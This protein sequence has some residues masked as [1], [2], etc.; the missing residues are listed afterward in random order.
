MSGER[1]RILVLHW[2]GC[3]IPA[4]TRH[5][6]RALA[7]PG[8]QYEVLFFDI[9]SG[10]PAAVRRSH[11]DAV[12]LHT[13]VFCLRWW[14]RF[15]WVRDHLGWLADLDCPRVALPQDEYDLCHILD[16]WLAE[17]NVS[18]I[19]T[20]FDERYRKLLY[21]R[22][23]RLATFH[24]CLT[25]YIDQAT[26]RHYERR[27]R[28]P[29]QRRL[30]LVYRA[31][32]LPFWYGCQGQL[33]HRIGTVFARRAAERGLRHDLSTRPE[34]RFYNN[35]WFDFLA[36]AR[37]TIGCESGTCTMDPQGRL[38]LRIQKLL[39]QEPNLT[40]EE[41]NRRLPPG[42]DDYRF[43]AISPR[44]FEA[45]ITRTGQILV[46]GE[47]NKILI[48]HR[49]YFPLR[50]D[51]TNLNEALDW[52]LD[53]RQVNRV[54]EAAYE[55][56]YRSGRYNYATLSD[57]VEEAIAAYRNVR[58]RPD[59]PPARP[60]FAVVR[61][62]CRLAHWRDSTAETVRNLTERLGLTAP[63]KAANLAAAF[64]G[65]PPLRRLMSYYLTHPSFRRQVGCKA[66]IRD[67]LLL[68]IL[69]NPSH[70]LRHIR[71]PFAVELSYQPDAQRVVIR[72]KP[73]LRQQTSQALSLKQQEAWEE[74]EQA[75]RLKRIHEVVWDHSR[76]GIYV[77]SFSL[78]G[79]YRMWL[80]WK[81]VHSFAGFL[82]FSRPNPAWAMQVLK[83][84]HCPLEIAAPFV[85]EERIESSVE[86]EPCWTVDLADP[87]TYTT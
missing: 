55:E 75:F 28:P 6:L 56:I 36:S 70:G 48:P 25:G 78:L 60:P 81:G 7:F 43:F 73:G 5:H 86:E 41:V 59:Q 20:N 9:R 11:F 32:H 54:T 13:T 22:M 84:I 74:L 24:P 42:W 2:S 19:C 31:A 57:I 61:R 64:L 68:E 77:D 49:H 71:I 50:R 80:S 15:E 3:P 44:H 33:K 62:M 45:V 85:P 52:S 30:D 87:I 23:H 69:A 39:A 26:A 65:N 66:I 40:F 12:V 82:E 1:R 63:M 27:L 51:F 17:M 67:L 38:R 29:G 16:A 10:V 18:A 37:A 4:T 46:E 72:S 35:R 34:D 53:D 58:P 79:R 76:C 8:R 47:Y 83:Q 14:P 21:P